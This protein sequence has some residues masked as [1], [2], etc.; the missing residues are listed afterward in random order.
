[1][2]L[3]DDKELG[4]ILRDVDGAD[5]ARAQMRQPYAWR[6]LHEKMHGAPT[7]AQAEGG[8]W[9]WAGLAAV[10]MLVAL[11]GIVALRPAS[12]E[13]GLASASAF[14]PQVQ[15][16]AFYA[17]AAQADVV[18]LTGLSPMTANALPGS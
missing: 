2:S 8:L 5:L 14:S 1:M 18:W 10:G 11:L 4:R 7:E 16:T 6:R 9:R 15:V 12:G 3:P 17:P 13:P